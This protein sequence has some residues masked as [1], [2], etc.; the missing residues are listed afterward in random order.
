[1]VTTSRRPSAGGSHEPTAI[2]RRYPQTPNGER[3]FRAPNEEDRAGCHRA[4]ETA[5]S[6]VKRRVESNGIL[7]TEEF[8]AGERLASHELRDDAWV[9][10]FTPR[11]A[12]TWHLRR[13]VRHVW[14]P[15]CAK[16]LGE[17]EGD[18]VLSSHRT[19]AGQGPQ[20]QLATVFLATSP[21]SM[22]SCLIDT[23]LR[24]SG[25]SQSSKVQT[26]CIRG[27]APS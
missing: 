8:P 24:S 2:R 10:F 22:R 6:A 13:G 1:M 18:A 17:D 23:I 15:R 16:D 21:E 19:D 9:D 12:R 14:C 25:R 4:A 7:P 5:L 3:T 11:Q 26:V 27:A 20:L